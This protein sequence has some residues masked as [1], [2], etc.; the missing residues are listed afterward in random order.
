MTSDNFVA[1][2]YF[3]RFKKS[4]KFLAIYPISEENESN[5]IS[6]NNVLWSFYFVN[7]FTLLLATVYTVFTVS[8]DLIS[9]IYSWMELTALF[10]SITILLNYK[11]QESRLK[12]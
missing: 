11:L 10:E 6:N 2:N 5:E 4:L 1:K 9:T 3:Y 7:Y 12:V 8:D